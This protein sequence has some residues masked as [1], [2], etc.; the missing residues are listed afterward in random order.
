MRDL[1]TE[2]AYAIADEANELSKKAKVYPMHIGDLNYPTSQIF[3][4]SLN[5]AIT[6]R[7]TGYCPAAGIP[8]LRNALAEEVGKRR[9]VKYT[10]DNVSVQSGGK[11]VIGKFLQVCMNPGDEVLYPKYYFT[12]F[13]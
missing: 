13:I 1:G 8:E 10:I 11:P 3:V 5:K 6:N 9:G 12:L 7:K 2:T 4:D